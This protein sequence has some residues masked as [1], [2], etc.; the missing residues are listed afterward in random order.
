MSSVALLD[1]FTTSH[2]LHRSSFCPSSVMIKSPKDFQSSF[3]GLP[4]LLAVWWAPSFGERPPSFGER[5]PS[6]GERPP[7]FGEGT[8]ASCP[9]SWVGGEVG[10]TAS[11]WDLLFLVARG[12]A[13]LL[14]WKFEE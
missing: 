14:A 2:H 11:A 9:S 3:S 13:V 1:G 8:E 4:L 12:I 10:T 5:Q 7:S 6:F